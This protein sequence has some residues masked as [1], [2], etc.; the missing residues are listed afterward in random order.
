MARLEPAQHAR[1]AATLLVSPFAQAVM[2]LDYVRHAAPVLMDKWYLLQKLSRLVSI[3]PSTEH[4][5]RV[6]ASAAVSWPA[7]IANERY[8][9]RS[10]KREPLLETSFIKVA[11]IRDVNLLSEARDFHC[12]HV[13]APSESLLPEN[14]RTSN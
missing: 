12:S 4:L 9:N 11:K 3:Q 8:R 2:E 7:H 13:I 10:V 5:H 14:S 1:A 6:S